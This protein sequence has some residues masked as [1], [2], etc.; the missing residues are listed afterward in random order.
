MSRRHSPSDWARLLALTLMW[1]SAFLLTKVAVTRIPPDLVVAGRLL[2]ACLLLIPAAVLMAKRPPASA[3]LALFMVLMAVLGYA[4][5]FS[6]VSWGQAFLDSGLAGILMAVM[7]LATLGLAHF[8]IPGERLTPYRVGGFLLGFAGVVV[9]MG[10]SAWSG[11]AETQAHL[12][13]MLAVLGGAFSYSVSAILARLRPPSDALY[14]ATTTTSLAAIMMVPAAFLGHA[15][16]D[17]VFPGTLPLVAVLLL[18]VFSTAAAAIIYFQLVKRAGPTFVSQLNY[19]IPL[20]AV[21]CGILFLGERPEARHLQ[22]LALILV[23]ILVTHLE[24]IV[25]TPRYAP[26]PEQSEP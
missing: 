7:P 5:P 24:Q 4:L 14:T 16:A 10:P 12:I 9:L 6:L 15:P 11:I 19:L 20:W 25:S 2:V 26:E 8:L 1:G 23:G 17:L 21:G 18:G 22:A 13:P 3:K